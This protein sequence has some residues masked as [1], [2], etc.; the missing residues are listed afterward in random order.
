MNRRRTLLAAVAGAVL[1]LAS[2]TGSTGAPTSTTTSPASPL[3]S[4]EASS[5]APTT[6]PPTPVAGRGSAQAARE[7]LCRRPPYP[8]LPH[9]TTAPPNAVISQV[10]DQVER[11]RS[12]DYIHPVAVDPVTQRELV[13]GIDRS[14]GSSFPREMYRRRSLAWQTIGVVP[15]GTDV[16]AA[17]HRLYST[18][19]VGY[20]DPTSKQLVFIGTDHPSPLERFTL[21]HELTH[22]DD[23][24]HFNLS[25]LNPLERHCQDEALMAASG[26]VEG[27]AVFFQFR[28]A[29]TFF[30]AGDMASIAAS[31]GSPPG[32]IPDF[33][34]SLFAWPYSDGPGFIGA[35][36]GRGGLDA[37]NGAL[38]DFPIS[39]EQVIH[40]E[41]YPNDVPQPLDISQLAPKLGKGWRDL[42]VMDVGEV[43]LNHMINPAQIVI[44]VGDVGDPADGWDGGLYRAWTDGTHVAVLMETAWDSTDQE[45]HFAA[46]AKAWLGDRPDATIVGAHGHLRL[47]FASDPDTLS[48]LKSA[49]GVQ[50]G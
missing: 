26:A 41:R 17:I 20:Y 2:C 5:P 27:S 30:S 18:Q 21:A 34:V 46:A 40:P 10:E 35:L 39:T 23:D 7:R 4:T 31:G 29:R 1:L 25:R 15:A 9:A 13:Q 48:L 42:D 38:R 47:L 19:V 50:A 24:Q 11:V 14:F 12:L 6:A 32:G 45:L 36:N 16:R 43:W 33:I 49:A 22:A 37:V 3:P 44:G 28:V 8:K